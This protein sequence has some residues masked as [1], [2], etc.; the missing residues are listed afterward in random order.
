MSEADIHQMLLE[1]LGNLRKR[2]IRGD[3]DEGE[4]VVNG[5]V[6]RVARHADG[7]PIY[8][9]YV[10]NDVLGG[11]LSPEAGTL[12]PPSLAAYHEKI[13][14]RC[15][16]GDLKLVLPPLLGILAI[17]R[18]PLTV[19]ALADLV[20]RQTRITQGHQFEA[21][22][23]QALSA[24]GAMVRRLST[25]EDEDGFTIFHQ[26]FRE[27]VLSSSRMAFIVE[28]A[29]SAMAEAALIPSVFG[30]T[31]A[32]RYLFRHGVAHL[33][34]AGKNDQAIS[35]L[36]DF[37]YL[38]ERL[39]M[40]QPGGT[41]GISKDWRL[42]Q[43]NDVVL[44]Q[45]FRQWEAFFREREHLLRRGDSIWPSY[46]ILLQTAV[47]HADDSPVTR[48]AEA[49]LAA[50]QCDWLWL[51]NPRRMAHAAPD[52]CLRV[53]EGHTGGVVG[54]SVMVNGRILSWSG[55][56]TLRLWTSEAVPFATLE[57]HN[58]RISGTTVLPDGR[59]LSWSESLLH[60]LPF[61]PDWSDFQHLR[62]T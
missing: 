52:P 57:G 22:L 48:Q 37:R 21:L 47:E 51:R 28:S 3:R 24:I 29:R 30:A 54:A 50:G 15:E 12:L 39:K 35:L 5:F 49:W 61:G 53:F 44:N 60:N 1:R 26:S 32:A 9:R 40:L 2:L 34:E 17:A 18:E 38:M 46:K 8:V 27:H 41:G 36:T 59:I 23:H 55:D 7:L 25:P 58:K 31:S 11:K 20:A 42:I 14:D 45:N 62:T 56:G 10:V 33:V 43:R 6:Q 4:K 19:P 16:I 13:L